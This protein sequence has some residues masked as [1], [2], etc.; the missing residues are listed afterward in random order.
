MPYLHIPSIPVGPFSVHAF[1]IVAACAVILG[2]K[3]TRCRA[4]ELGLDTGVVDRLMPWLL[5]G[6]ALGAH[7]LAVLLYYPQRLVTEPWVLL[8]LWDG[9]SS[10]G[11]ILGGLV[12]AFL[13]FRKLG[14]KM[15]HYKQALLFGA[16]VGLLV[17]RFGCAVTH[18]HPGKE[19]TAP[20]AVQGWPTSATPERG[21]GFYRDGPRR[22]DLGL[23]EFLYLI[24]L[25]AILYCLRRYSPFEDFH[26]VLV[27]MLYMPARFLL[28]F[29]READKRYVGLTPGQYLSV[30]FLVLAIYLACRGLKRETRP[31]PTEVP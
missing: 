12:A 15:K 30:I 23:Y 28:D 26:I 24:P 3:A 9:L 14:L 7:F 4:A 13:F 11:G 29:L 2:I 1:G 22:H 19:T 10:F 25:T 18:D 21:L 5:I 16:V 17:G 27:L 8:R 6:V 31:V 20:I